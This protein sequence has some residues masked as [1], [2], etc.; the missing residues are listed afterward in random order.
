VQEWPFFSSARRGAN[1]RPSP[2]RAK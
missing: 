1:I 2:P